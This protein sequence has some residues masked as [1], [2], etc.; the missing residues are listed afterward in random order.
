MRS[1]SEQT[2][3][4]T[5]AANLIGVAPITLKRW[6]LEGKINDVQRDRRGWRV[7]TQ[8]DINRIKAHTEYAK[9]PAPKQLSLYTKHGEAVY[10][11]K[12]SSFR[13]S[14]F[15]GN[16]KLPFHRW[17]PWIAGFSSN[18][19]EDCFNNYLD[20]SVPHSEITILDPFAGVGTTLT[21]GI[22]HGYN[23]VGFEINPYAYFCRVK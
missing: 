3:F 21:E 16:K 22:M 4:L 7:F 6:L 10:E 23:V 13:D 19:V 8:S 14:A 11:E 2:F 20:R 18:F 12:A 5:T 15:N 17:V 9:Q 1:V